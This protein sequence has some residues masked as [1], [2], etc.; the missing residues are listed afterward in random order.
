MSDKE[1]HE[2]WVPDVAKRDGVEA[3]DQEW[4]PE[5]ADAG[6]APDQEWLPEHAGAGGAPDQEWLP[7]H[8]EVEGFERDG[9]RH[10]RCLFCS[11]RVEATR[12]A[13]DEHQASHA[14]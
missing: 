3:P 7:E 13:V 5:N 8:A 6:G 14:S 12:P 2:N 11:G 1:L 9:K 4:V 10:F